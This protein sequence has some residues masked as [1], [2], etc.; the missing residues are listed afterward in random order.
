M[1][2]KIW[3]HQVRQIPVRIRRIRVLKIVV[4]SPI[5]SIERNFPKFNFK[6]KKILFQTFFIKLEKIVRN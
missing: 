5:K 2:I 1:R 3:I 4:F 6:M